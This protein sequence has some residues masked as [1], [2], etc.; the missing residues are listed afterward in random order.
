MDD[1]AFLLLDI[2]KLPLNK[3]QLIGDGGML[4]LLPHA[5]VIYSSDLFKWY[6]LCIYFIIIY[7]VRQTHRFKTQKCKFSFFSKRLPDRFITSFIKLR[8]SYYDIIMNLQ[9]YD[10]LNKP[11]FQCKY[12]K[13]ISVNPKKLVKHIVLCKKNNE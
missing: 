13:K 7:I 12:C 6:I 9:K 3:S 5:G 4:W 8:S 11:R 10:Q 2:L 1:A